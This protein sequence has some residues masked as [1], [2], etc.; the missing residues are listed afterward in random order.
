LRELDARAVGANPGSE[1]MRRLKEIKMVV[2]NG[3]H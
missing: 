3:T 2:E 1:V